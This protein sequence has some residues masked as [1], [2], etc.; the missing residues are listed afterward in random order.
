MSR[1]FLCGMGASMASSSVVWVIIN[2]LLFKN[3]L[4][5]HVAPILFTIGIAISLYG[6]L[7][8]EDEGA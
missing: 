7:K 2:E 1:N 3:H 8:K 4:L 6:F 5:S